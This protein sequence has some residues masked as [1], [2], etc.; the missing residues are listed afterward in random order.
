MFVCQESLW[1]LWRAFQPKVHGVPPWAKVMSM[2]S[3]SQ[4]ALESTWPPPSSHHWKNI[5]VQLNNIG[6]KFSHPQN[7]KERKDH[8]KIVK[9]GKRLGGERIRQKLQKIDI[10]P[11]ETK[12]TQ[13][14]NDPDKKLDDWHFQM[15]D[16]AFPSNEL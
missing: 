10:D 2:M 3:L 11:A 9:G 7:E 8:V 12:E 13:G 6:S 15:E 4:D 16:M 1:N 5:V 14:A